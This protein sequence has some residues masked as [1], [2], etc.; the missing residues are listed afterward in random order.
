M[1]ILGDLL[2]PIGQY[3]GQKDTNQAN[4]DIAAETNAANQANAREMMAFQERMSN[5]AHTR[6]VADLKAAGLN[7]ILAMNGGASTPAGA[8]ATAVGAQMSNPMAGFGELGQKNRALNLQEQKQE[9]E[10]KLLKAQ[11]TQAKAAARKANTEADVLAGEK[12][13]SEIKQDLYNFGKTQIQK[14]QD[15]AKQPSDATQEHMK[16]FNERIQKQNPHN[17]VN[18]IIRGLR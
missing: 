11:E 1:G 3:F 7:P 10:V 4:K 15:S 6:E 12:P 14:M 9:S 5:T 13:M 17:N 18:P 2:G 16:R 8:M